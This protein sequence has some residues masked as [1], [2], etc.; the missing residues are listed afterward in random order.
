MDGLQAA[1]AQEAEIAILQLSNASDSLEFLTNKFTNVGLYDWM[2]GVLETYLRVPVAAGHRNGEAGGKS[3]GVR[4]AA[5]SRV[6][7]SAG[8]LGA[9]RRYSGFRKLGARPKRPDRRRAAAAGFDATGPIRVSQRQA[10]TVSHQDKTLSMAPLAPAEF[11]RFWETGVMRFATPMELFDRDFSGHFLRLIKRV[12]MSG[13]AHIPPNQ[14]I[15]ATLSA[16]GISWVVVEGS[17]FQRVA[18]TRDPESV[19]ISSPA[20][21]NGIFDLAPQASG[22]LLPFEDSCVDTAYQRLLR[23]TTVAVKTPSLNPI[24]TESPSFGPCSSVTANAPNG[25]SSIC[26]CAI[27]TMAT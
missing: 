14:G 16:S 6:L 22:M 24:R 19:A 25:N 17:G 3:T 18:I 9:A 10:K 13:I 11:Q 5:A 15:T 26:V 21:A 2:S 20:N 23:L 7:N 4:T 12:R 1:A 8:L 27:F